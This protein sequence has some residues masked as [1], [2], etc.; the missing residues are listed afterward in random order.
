MISFLPIYVISKKILPDTVK[1]N[2]INF[3]LNNKQI[4][5]YMSL[6]AECLISK[7]KFYFFDKV[8]G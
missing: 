3:E 8:L 5:V 1:Q 7:I 4:N 6:L 2:L